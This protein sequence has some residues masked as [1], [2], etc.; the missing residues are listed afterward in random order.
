MQYTKFSFVPDIFKLKLHKIGLTCTDPM[1]NID[2]IVAVG[3]EE[4][5]PVPELSHPQMDLF[6]KSEGDDISIRKEAHYVKALMP[7]ITMGK[8]TTMGLFGDL[9]KIPKSCFGIGFEEKF[10]KYFE[11][12]KKHRNNV[13]TPK[14]DIPTGS[15]FLL[16]APSKHSYGDVVGTVFKW[17]PERIPGFG[18][19]QARYNK[20]MTRWNTK[21]YQLWLNGNDIVDTESNGVNEVYEKEMQKQILRKK[22]YHNHL[23]AWT[24]TGYWKVEQETV[25]SQANLLANLIA[26]RDLSKKKADEYVEMPREFIHNDTRGWHWVGGDDSVIR[27][28]RSDA[29]EYQAEYNSKIR[30]LQ[31][32]AYFAS[33]QRFHYDYL[34]NTH[35]SQLTLSQH[36][37]IFNQDDQLITTEAIY[38]TPPPAGMTHTQMKWTKYTTHNW[39]FIPGA[40]IE[41]IDGKFAYYP[42]LTEQEQTQNQI[43]YERDLAAAV[44]PPGPRA[45]LSHPEYQR[46]KKFEELRKLEPKWRYMILIYD[47]ELKVKVNVGREHF[48]STTDNMR[49]DGFNKWLNPKSAGY[50]GTSDGLT[51]PEYKNY[52]E[53]FGGHKLGQVN[54]DGTITP[55]YLSYHASWTLAHGGG[56]N[57]L[58]WGIHSRGNVTSYSGRPYPGDWTQHE[59]SL[60]NSWWSSKKLNKS[61]WNVPPTK[62]PK[63]EL[64]DAGII[65]PQAKLD[66]NLK[67]QAPK[68]QISSILLKEGKSHSNELSDYIINPLCASTHSIDGKGGKYDWT[69]GCL[70]GGGE[71]DS[72]FFDDFG[73]NGIFEPTERDVDE[74][75][76][77]TEAWVLLR[78]DMTRVASSI[79]D[80]GKILHIIKLEKPIDDFIGTKTI[81]LVGNA[82]DVCEMEFVTAD[83]NEG[84]ATLTHDTSPNAS[85]NSTATF[86]KTSAAIMTQFQTG[87]SVW[88]VH[89]P[90][91]TTK[92]FYQEV[93][94]IT[95]V[96]DY[97]FTYNTLKGTIPPSDLTAVEWEWTN[98]NNGDTWKMDTNPQIWSKRFG[99]SKFGINT[100]NLGVKVT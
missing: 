37:E 70:V 86:G 56:W 97:S 43:I 15:P 46:M 84:T 92:I 94:E 10:R 9:S 80:V 12:Y 96:D 61:M 68:Q 2:K 32:N 64:W 4:D 60:G 69:T 7:D 82:N 19:G 36:I 31:W 74:F 21:N 30:E 78:N 33:S 25:D 5:E 66:H 99:C 98:P 59:D 71:F 26:Q 100:L 49:E 93:P 65:D 40:R 23:K 29:K 39:P 51:S 79:D 6:Y 77:T 90:S 28:H 62:P 22:R 58:K 75:G 85:R 3:K 91:E 83:H 1:I 20:A 88:I 72:E 48:L 52:L 50:T 57:E 41:N 14:D 76:N 53:N 34:M 89:H 87:D 63:V 38:K 45:P 73:S 16:K 8:I 42:Q 95:K 27:N 35:D 13:Y 17:Y 54:D 24:P 81:E 44:P 11:G 55:G 47:N 18:D 67:I